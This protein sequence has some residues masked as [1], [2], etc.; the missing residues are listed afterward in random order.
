MLLENSE[1]EKKVLEIIS[2]KLDYRDIINPTDSFKK[3]GIESMMFIKIIV[4]LENEFDIEFDDDSLDLSE[5]K[6]VGDIAYKVISMI[7]NK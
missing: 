7:D 4:E 2:K 1:L 6:N 5:F 3:V